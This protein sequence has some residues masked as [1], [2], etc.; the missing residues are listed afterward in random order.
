MNFKKGDLVTLEITDLAFG[1]AGV[2]KISDTGYQAA[3][4]GDSRGVSQ[5]VS[6]AAN[7]V[8]FVEAT[9]PGDIVSA[10]FTKIK[11]QYGQ[12]RL[13]KILKPSSKR[14][15]PRCKHFGVCG[16]CS[17]QFLS[18]EDQLRWK[19]KMVTDALMR[20]GG[21]SNLPL[22]PIIGCENP[23]FYRNKM[24]YT[25]GQG[26]IIGLHPKKNFRD[27]FDLQEC[28]LQSPLSVKIAHGVAAWT[29]QNNLQQEFLKNLVVREGKN[30]G[31]TLL[32]LIT[33]ADDDAW[34]SKFADFIGQQFPEVTSLY[35]TAV[36]V[37]KNRRTM[38]KEYLL[39]G[40]PVLMESLTVTV[41]HA[42][43][44]QVPRAQNAHG[45]TANSITLAFD[46]LPQAFFQTNTKQAEVL[47]RK[48]LAFAEPN[49]SDEVLDLF[50]GTGTI[51][52]FFAKRG[53]KKVTGVEINPSAIE[54]ARGNA[55]KNNLSN[56]EF[57]CSD[58]E[59]I[60][61]QGQE[62]KTASL[63]ITDPPRAGIFPRALEKIL[64]QRFPKWIYVSCNP[65]TLARDLKI[66]SENGYKLQKIQPVDM[67]PQTY[68]I[69]A[70]ALL[71][72][73]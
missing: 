8:I 72:A 6:E 26:G 45:K 23:W 55:Q 48:I 43:G 17:L 33:S 28:F 39:K 32:N 25:F 63:L 22:A 4:A 60:F 31:E 11:K 29:A 58:I 40:K 21:F 15:T 36:L 24:E 70:I 1:G 53:A 73:A 41:E 30:T 7:F 18:Y 14:T 10:R 69:E 20:L 51:G 67:F 64:E 61:S 12:A 3:F 27:V 46:I 52:M 2:G 37:Q 68:H 49:T 62:E 5:T 13:E 35:R 59:A 57:Y 16:G 50:C 42:T 44:E 19:E 65:T 71:S 34:D 54:S 38:I 9:V 56:I 47:Y 66:A